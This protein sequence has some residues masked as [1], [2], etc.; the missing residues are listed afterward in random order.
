MAA[1]LPVAARLG[2]E[3][4]YRWPNRVNREL[5]R[6]SLLDNLVAFKSIVNLCEPSR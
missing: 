1:A 6:C 4:P 5:T 2:V 3:T